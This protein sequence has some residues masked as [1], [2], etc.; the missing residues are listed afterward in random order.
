MFRK[1]DA[2][3]Q[4]KRDSIRSGKRRWL[5]AEVLCLTFGLALA[6]AQQTAWEKYI[7][8]GQ[9]AYEQGDYPEAQK[10]FSAALEEADKFGPDDPRVAISLAWLTVLNDTQILGPEHPATATSLNDLATLYYG[11]GQYVQI[12]PLLQRALAIWE[13]ALGPEHPNV[14]IS[15]NNLAGLYRD[16]GHYA[17]AE[18]LMQ[19]S[20]A[21]SEKALGPENPRVAD[22]LEN[23]AL[24]LRKMGRDAEA[25]KME[26]RAQAIRTKHAQENPQK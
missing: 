23:Y 17:Q 11:Q 26:A 25:D 1:L 3:W 13:K 16:Q 4:N 21:I 5:L 14:G 22:S 24:L 15:L 20:L 8:A 6:S 18:P 12:E 19:R 10:I 7:E 9:Q 2:A